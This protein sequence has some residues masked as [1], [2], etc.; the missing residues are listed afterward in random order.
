MHAKWKAVKTALRQRYFLDLGRGYRNTILLT[1]TGRSG[2]TWIAELINHKNEYRYIFEPFHPSLI[3]PSGTVDVNWYLRPEGGDE[4]TENFL[5]Q[6]LSGKLRSMWSDQ[7]NEKVVCRA[8]LVKAIR[9][10]LWLGWIKKNCRSVVIVLLIRNPFAVAVSRMQMSEGWEWKPEPMQFLEQKELLDDYLH[11]YKELVE[12]IIDPFE[13]CILAWCIANYVPLCQFEPG[14]I[15]VVFY[16]NVV[17]NPESELK[18]L[19]QFIGKC[20]DPNVL[21]LRERPSRVSRQVSDRTDVL[22][23]LNSWRNYLSDAQVAKG[24][25]LIRQFRLDHLYGN[26]DVPQVST[27]QELLL[28]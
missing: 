28:T 20:W 8:R 2:S 17:T 22:G 5:R 7:L 6:V 11:P 27:D 18:Q 23:S 3:P 14:E 10:N 19:F 16:E 21:G 1:S 4:T 26:S 24:L 15:R 12:R 13:I 9:A 25:E